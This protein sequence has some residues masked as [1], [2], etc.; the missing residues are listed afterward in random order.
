MA[1][2]VQTTDFVGKYK[3]TQN[4]LQTSNL[5]SFIDKYEL[6]YLRD[7]LG[8]ELATL[9]LA[10]ITTNYAGPN[11]QKYKD[12]YNSF[13]SDDSELF[14]K[15]YYSNGIKEMLT[16][17]IYFEYVRTTATIHTMTGVVKPQNEVSS[18]ASFEETNLYSNYNEAM[19]SYKAIQKFICSN[20]TDY[21]EYNGISKQNNHWAI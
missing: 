4:N 12:I 5:Q 17:F 2:I 20:S 6:K 11:T 16:G 13:A 19:I 3:L 21:A 7:L 1:K 10:D 15:Q 18:I 9:L 14:C 8:V